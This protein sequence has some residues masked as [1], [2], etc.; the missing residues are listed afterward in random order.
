VA[1][2]DLCR[3]HGVA[4]STLY[5]WKAKYGDLEGSEVRRLKTLEDENTLL[6]P[7]V[8]DP[9]LDIQALK[10]V[11]SKKVLTPPQRRDAVE[12]MRQGAGLSERRVCQLVGVPPRTCGYRPTRAD[13]RPLQERLRTLATRWPRFGYRRLG[14]LLHR[15]GERVNPSRMRK[16]S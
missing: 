10:V 16:N 4:D 14:M 5:R 6:K 1:P 12:A 9:A 2:T 3:P 8:A 11:L 13:D 15:E 7:L